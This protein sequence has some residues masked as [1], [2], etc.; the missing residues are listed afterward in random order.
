MKNYVRPFYVKIWKVWERITVK[1][2]GKYPVV[3][4]G[5]QRSGTNY[6]TELL[7]NAD[8]NVINKIDPKRNDPRHKHFRWQSNKSTIQMDSRYVNKLTAS[9]IDDINSICC[10][11]NDYKHLVLY[12]NPTVWLNSIY[13]WGLE[14][15]WF[16]SEEEF[17]SLNLHEKYL[18]EWD[19]YYAFWEMLSDRNPEQVLLINHAD[20]AAQPNKKINEIDSFMNIRRTDEVRQLTVEKIRHSRPLNEKRVTLK[21]IDVKNYLENESSYNFSFR[22]GRLS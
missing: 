12:R 6:L 13:R 19:A 20:L 8:Y 10:Y 7:V 3:I 1:N 21:N 2:T 17:I 15:Q 22:K 5:I 16:E 14:C 4:Q 9:N 11:P 18:I